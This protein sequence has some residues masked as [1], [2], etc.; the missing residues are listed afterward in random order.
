MSRVILVMPLAVLQAPA[1][2][3][4]LLLRVAG[5]LIALIVSG[6]SHR[7]TAVRLR[8]TLIEGLREWLVA[9]GTTMKAMSLGQRV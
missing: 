1:A 7:V 5:E 6:D 8:L 2:R 4:V 3:A 9:G